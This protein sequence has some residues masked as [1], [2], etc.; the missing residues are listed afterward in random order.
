MPQ[1]PAYTQAGSTALGGFG[2]F[3][4]IVGGLMQFDPRTGATR[5]IAGDGVNARDH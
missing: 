4:N 1:L 2:W 3:A 5:E